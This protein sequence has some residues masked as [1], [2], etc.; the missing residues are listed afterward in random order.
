MIRRLNVKNH[1][2]EAFQRLYTQI[3]D[4]YSEISILSKKT[5]DGKINTF[6][7]EFV[8]Q[9]LS[10][11]NEVLSDQNKPFSDF[12]TFS[13]DDMPSYSDVVL[14]ISQYLKCLERLN[15]DGIHLLSGRRSG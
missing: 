13:E 10:M 5:P 4:I 8:N 9:L 11:A 3:Q 14:V 12:S 7:L 2:T 1:S 6:K 15:K